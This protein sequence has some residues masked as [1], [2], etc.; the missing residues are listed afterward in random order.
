MI[1]LIH[2]VPTM[3][4][5]GRCVFFRAFQHLDVEAHACT[6]IHT[7]KQAGKNLSAPPNVLCAKIECVG[8]RKRSLSKAELTASAARQ[9]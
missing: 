1:H 2:G 3:Y 7:Y 6:Y 4:G 8:L 9:M 5:L